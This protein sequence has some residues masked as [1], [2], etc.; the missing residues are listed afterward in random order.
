MKS[1]SMFSFASGFSPS[2]LKWFTSVVACINSS[3]PF[4]AELLVHW[5]SMLQIVYIFSCYCLFWLFPIFGHFCCD[6]AAISILV[7]VF[8]WTYI[9]ILFSIYLGVGLPG[10]WV[11]AVSSLQSV[12]LV[13]TPT[14]SVE[15][16]WLLHILVNIWCCQSFLVLALQV[17]V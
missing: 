2:M 8:L 5:I 7:Q 14:S 17:R 4:V 11:E 1:C 9:F 15:A 13:D 6:E 10:Y 3:F 16:F 12:V